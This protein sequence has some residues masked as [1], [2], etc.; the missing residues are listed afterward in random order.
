MVSQWK[1]QQHKISLRNFWGLIVLTLTASW[2]WCFC[3]LCCLIIPPGFV[4]FVCCCCFFLQDA[5]TWDT[6]FKFTSSLNLMVSPS[7]I[8]IFIFSYNSPRIYKFFASE[9]Q[10]RKILRCEDSIRKVVILY[11]SQ[12]CNWNFSHHSFLKNFQLLQWWYQSNNPILIG[13]I[14]LSE[15]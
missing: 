2:S 6:E 3:Y 14:A 8:I 9:Y 5:R 10:K 7:V 12:L 15:L 11:L 1:K 13:S 4:C